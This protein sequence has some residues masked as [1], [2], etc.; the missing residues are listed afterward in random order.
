MSR[1]KPNAGSTTASSGTGA[2]ASTG[3]ANRESIGASTAN[4]NRD[5]KTNQSQPARTAERGM[6]DRNAESSSILPALMSNPWLMTNAFLANP[7]GFARIMNQEMD[8][9]VSSTPA[10]VSPHSQRGGSG[11]QDSRSLDV[12]RPQRG[13]TQWSPQVEV[14]H[15]GN[16][17]TVCADLPGLSAKDIDIQVEDGIL[18]ISGERHQS[19]EDKK[20]GYYRSERSYGSFSRSVALP[21]GVDEDQIRAKFDNGVLE[22]TVPVPAQRQRGRRVEIQSGG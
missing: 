11:S 7:F 21:D 1:E 15:N 4:A 17:L 6:A 5:T 8:R 2:T 12:S 18:T 22:V 20:E 13:M 10:D 19:S 14:R 16:E 3:M 9:L